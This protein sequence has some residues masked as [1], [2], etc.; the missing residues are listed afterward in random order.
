LPVGKCVERGMGPAAPEAKQYG[1]GTLMVTPA[2]PCLYLVPAGTW[3]GLFLS[4]LLKQC[5]QIS[6]SSGETGVAML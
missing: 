5:P 2:K 1:M 3:V 6:E 4:P